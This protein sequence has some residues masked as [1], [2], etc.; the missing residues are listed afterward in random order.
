MFRTL[1]VHYAHGIRSDMIFWQ[2]NHRQILWIKYFSPFDRHAHFSKQS[3]KWIVAA[4]TLETAE[5]LQMGLIRISAYSAFLVPA[6]YRATAVN[7]NNLYQSF[8]TTFTPI[9]KTVLADDWLFCYYFDLKQLPWMNWISDSVNVAGSLI[10]SRSK[11]VETIW[12][13]SYDRTLQCSF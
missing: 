1:R 5:S 3:G 6:I 10:K 12:N 7:C 4:E 13:I 11:L 9:G 8:S 2:T